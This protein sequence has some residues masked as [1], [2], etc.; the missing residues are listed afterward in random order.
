[1]KASYHQPFDWRPPLLVVAGTGVGKE[2]VTPRIMRWLERAE[3][4]SGTRRL[5]DWWPDH[6]GVKVPFQT[7]MQ[8]TLL[9]LEQLSREKRVMVLAS[10]DP[11]YFG[12]GRRLVQLFGRERLLVLPNVSSV[13]VLFARLAEPWDD[14][15]VVSVH[16][17]DELHWVEEVRRHPRVVLFT[18]PQHSPA[19]VA[20]QLIDSGVTD[21]DV[22]VAQDLG[23]AA[24]KIEILPVE[25]ALRHSFAELNL[26]AL[27]ARDK[28]IKIE[29]QERQELW[30]MVGIPDE[31]FQHQAGLITKMEVRVAVLA[32]L[33]LY[34][35]L[36]LWDLGAGSGSV[37]IEAARLARLDKVFAVEKDAGRHA[38]LLRTSDRLARGKVQ[39]ILGKAP[40]ILKDL[41]DPDRVFIGG[42]G[43]ELHTILEVIADR[44]RPGGRVV[45]TAVT[46][47]TL[48]AIRSFWQNRAF[49]Q[50]VTQL[51]INRST[52]IGDS[53]RLEALNPVFVV[54][55]WR[56]P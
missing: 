33:Q 30:P 36:V 51:Q 55:A 52:P 7:P 29:E 56:K 27:F 5:L 9:E 20:Q 12:V 2:D 3:V 45:Q 34:P 53:L 26:V 6:P 18:D 40:E 23:S 15:H 4:L 39:A 44:L 1:V 24:E 16:G 32:S 31:A 25:E 8:T 49:A 54:T 19:W 28:A 35:N 48:E 22:V 41:P 17:R 21:R 46:L 13:Q 43:G 42:S 14:V 38:D 37:A 50:T 11:L 47:N 10:G